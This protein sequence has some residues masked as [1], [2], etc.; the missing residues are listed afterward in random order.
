MMPDHTSDGFLKAGG[1]LYPFILEALQSSSAKCPV[2]QPFLR[3]AGALVILDYPSLVGIL[4]EGILLLDPNYMGKD[5][6]C[7]SDLSLVGSDCTSAI[8]L[9]TGYSLVEEQLYL[10]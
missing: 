4:K 9:E 1:L 3:Q 5:F 8:L 2:Q 7:L 6:L 10:M